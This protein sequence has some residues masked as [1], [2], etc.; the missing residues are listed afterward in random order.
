M[1]QDKKYTK[2]KYKRV[3]RDWKKWIPPWRK[4]YHSLPKD[5]NLH[6]FEELMTLDMKVLVDYIFLFNEHHDRIF[7]HLSLMCKNL[8]GQLGALGAQSF[9]EKMISSANLIIKK[10]TSIDNDLLYKF[11]VLK[12]NRSFMDF[13][14]R[15]L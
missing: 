7:G 14:K 5:K 1:Q 12:I 15:K 10:R 3:I 13:F 6:I 4:L 2:A 8:M 9:A 11:L